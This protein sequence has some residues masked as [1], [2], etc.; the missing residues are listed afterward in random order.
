MMTIQKQKEIEALNNSL[1]KFEPSKIFIEW[2]PSAQTRVD[3]TYREY[4]Q[5]KYQLT[6]NEV[7]QLGFRLAKELGHNKVYCMDAPGKY[8]ADTVMKTAARAGQS[9]YIDSLYTE[10][11]IRALR[12]DSIQ[13]LLPLKERLSIINLEKNIMDIH[14]LNVGTLVA[15]YVGEVG[16]YAGAEFMGEW[17]K[18]NIRM[19]S[20]IVRSIE[21]EDKAILIIV[22]AGHARILQHF[23]EDDPGFEVVSPL[24]FLE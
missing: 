4:L 8:M 16:D 10:W 1:E 20:N 21:Q 22:G 23:F 2:R 9:R 13:S 12:E 24:S 18:R 14:A 11:T 7:H 15:P 19:F 17:Y 3:S 6:A 5:G